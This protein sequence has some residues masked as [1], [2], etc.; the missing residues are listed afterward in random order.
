[1]TVPDFPTETV[2]A[3][4]LRPGDYFLVSDG[5][6]RILTVDVEG[7]MVGFTARDSYDGTVWVGTM[8]ADEPLWILTRT[9]SRTET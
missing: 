3:A 6:D 7:A 9:R 8:P 4:D 5:A 1:M 2:D